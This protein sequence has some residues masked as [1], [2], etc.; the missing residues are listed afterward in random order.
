MENRQIRLRRGTIAVGALAIIGIFMIALSCI[1]MVITEYSR[2]AYTVKSINEVIAKKVKEKLIVERIDN[3]N[4]RVKNE[5]STT[6][7]II[8]VLAVKDENEVRYI[9]LER[10]EIKCVKILSE[11]PVE[12]DKPIRDD[13]RVGVI[14]SYGNIFW[15][16]KD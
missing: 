2:Y 8:A 7:F 6:S 15:E 12:P 11:E 10:G 14:T 9:K 3:K 16:E 5:G 4:F 1:V 13:E